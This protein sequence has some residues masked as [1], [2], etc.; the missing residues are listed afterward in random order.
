MQSSER[1][2]FFIDGSNFYHALKKQFN[3]TAIDVG[4]FC[5]IMVTGRKLVGIN[6][7]TAPLTGADPDEA[8][9]AQQRFF[10]KLRGN[11]LL[12]LKLGRLE[13]RKSRETCTLCMKEY[14]VD[15]RVEKGVDVNIAVDMMSLA[16]AKVY[17]TAVL[18]SGDGDFSVAI[19]EIHKLTA[20]RVEVAYPKGS[21]AYHL[22]RV[23]KSFTAFSAQDIWDSFLR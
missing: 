7:Y 19:Q 12:T 9:K 17:D 22:G 1:V 14:V 23:A 4:R 3:Q 5:E 18:V 8:Q 16:F 13:P 21:E 2:F 6:F 20:S 11:R 15:Y 10:S